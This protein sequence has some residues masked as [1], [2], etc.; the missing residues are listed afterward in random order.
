MNPFTT[1]VND[2][3]K[4]DVPD[5]KC[6][7]QPQMLLA[8]PWPPPTRKGKKDTPMVTP[9]CKNLTGHF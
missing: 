2:I 6:R 7:W 3:I 4:I 1:R 8:L 5:V 9:F